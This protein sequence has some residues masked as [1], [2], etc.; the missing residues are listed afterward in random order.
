MKTKIAISM[1]C[2]LSVAY[3]AAD[4]AELQKTLQANS[5]QGSIISSSDLASGLSMIIIDVNNQQVPFLATNDGKFIFEPN[6]LLIQDKAVQTKIQGFYKDF[7]EK[8]KAKINIKLQEVFKK[9]SANVFHFKSQ[10]NGV[11]TIYVVSDAN[12]PYCQK[13]FAN[14]NKRLEDANVELLVVGFLGED[15]M[16]KAANALKNKSG[17]QAKDIAMLAKLYEP[18]RKATSMDTKL[19]QELTQAV[20]DTGVRSVPYIIED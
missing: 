17:N 13:E 14:L 1:L 10:K 11:K 7:Y 15:S 20:A 9:Q 18:K 16:L 5:V 2:A 6:A 19:A 12:C 4:K 3:S 8:E